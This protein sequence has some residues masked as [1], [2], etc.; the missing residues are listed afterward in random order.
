MKPERLQDEFGVGEHLKNIQRLLLAEP[1]KSQCQRLS[2]AQQGELSRVSAEQKISDSRDS[3]TCHF[4][5]L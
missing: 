4:V 1:E 5:S 2:Q 3:V